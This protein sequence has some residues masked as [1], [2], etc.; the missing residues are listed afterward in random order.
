MNVIPT[1]DGISMTIHICKC[2]S[3]NADRQSLMFLNLV[4]RI[5]QKC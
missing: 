2:S 1:S 4:R 5:P 3:S